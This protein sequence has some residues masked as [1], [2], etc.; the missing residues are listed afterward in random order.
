M[1]AK[2]K[3]SNN[4]VVFA[5]IAIGAVVWF[6]I[7]FWYII[8]GL[9]VAA[10]LVFVAVQLMKRNNARHERLAAERAQLLA[11]CEEENQQ[12]VDDPEKYLANL[13]PDLDIPSS[14]K[15]TEPPQHD[16]HDEQASTGQETLEEQ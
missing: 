13:Q 14:Q 5:V 11:R 6:V 3:D 2:S 4:L 12:Y 9:I 7:K 8:V 15:R 1:A 16:T 10:A